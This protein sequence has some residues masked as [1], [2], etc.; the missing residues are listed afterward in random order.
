MKPA[1][2]TLSIK[3]PPGNLP[4]VATWG[5][6]AGR[7]GFWCITYSQYNGEPVVFVLV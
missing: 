1:W 5:G 4:P 7:C 2:T 3:V 6:Q